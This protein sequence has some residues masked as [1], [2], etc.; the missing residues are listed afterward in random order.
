MMSDNRFI[1]CLI[2][3][4]PRALGSLFIGSFGQSARFAQGISQNKF[5]LRIETS[6]IVIRPALHRG[7][8][9]LIHA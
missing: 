5:D 3:A 6:Q 1:L 4:R 2:V 7:V 8:R 9:F